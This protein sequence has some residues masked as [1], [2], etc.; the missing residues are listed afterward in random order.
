MQRLKA[1]LVTLLLASVAGAA[2]GM[3]AGA[4][5]YAPRPGEVLVYRIYLAGLALGQQRITVREA[6]NRQKL[7]LEVALDSLHALFGLADY[8]ER[9]SILW[10]PEAA[11]PLYEEAAIT[12]RKLTQSERLVFDPAG[13]LIRIQRTQADGAIS[14]ET[15]PYVADTQTN[16]SLLTYLR[17]FPWEK[18]RTAVALLTGSNVGTYEFVVAVETRTVRVPFG[19]FTQCWHVFNKELRYDIWFDRGPG[20]LPLEVRSRTNLGMAS[21]K[22]VE[23]GGY[24]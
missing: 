7:R 8:H 13:G 11:R 19:S 4:E 10:D 15:T 9:R 18:G 12:Q 16:C 1:L 20:H 22:L 21:M 23:A 17:T 2:T 3:A 6:E 24:R 14:Q 5:V